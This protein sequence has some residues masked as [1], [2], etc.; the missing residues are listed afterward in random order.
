MMTRKH[1]KAIAAILAGKTVH[2]SIRT[3]Y[4]VGYACAS[5][6]IAKEL[7][8]LFEADNPRFDRTRFLAACG[9]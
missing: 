2:D 5:Q 3:D 7:S 6:D 1:F 8:D 4:D 9:M